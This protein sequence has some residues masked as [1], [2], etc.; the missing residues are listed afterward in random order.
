MPCQSIEELL[1]LVFAWL[2]KQTPFVVEDKV[3]SL[4]QAA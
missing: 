1:E 3:Y 4:P 2:H